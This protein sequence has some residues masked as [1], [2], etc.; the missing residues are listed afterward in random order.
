MFKHDRKAVH[1][2]NNVARWAIILSIMVFTILAILIIFIDI[3]F[4]KSY[5]HMKDDLF[6]LTLI[7][8]SGIICVLLIRFLV[9]R[10][11]KRLN[12]TYFQRFEHIPDHAS[13]RE[14]LWCKNFPERDKPKYKHAVLLLHGFAASTQEFQ[15]LLPALKENNIPFLAPS[16]P[17]FG[18]DRVKLLANIN[19]QDWLR[20]CMYHYDMLSEI[21][22][23]VSII[24]HSMGSLLAT[25][26]ASHRPVKGLILSGPAMFVVDRDK[27]L[28]KFFTNKYLSD[29]Y[30]WIFPFFPKPIHKDRK[31]VADMIDDEHLNEIF[32]YISC[33]TR[34]VKQLALLQDYVNILES[35]PQ[36]LHL[37]Y[38]KYETTINVK[39]LI[40]LLDENKIKYTQKEYENSA[41]SAFEDLDRKEAADDTV[42]LLLND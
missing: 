17:G 22:D 23:E 5:F 21:A 3:S 28:K 13:F 39:G 40:Q 30:V 15:Y 2:R 33:P 37:I 29:I 14:T 34:A 7:F 11:S 20:N 18:R 6:R 4:T 16:I 10:L 24:G 9:S 26:I 27:K 41:H 19:F 32:Q 31:S 35:T 1:Q 36:K 12:E 42:K 25:Y 38:G 8:L